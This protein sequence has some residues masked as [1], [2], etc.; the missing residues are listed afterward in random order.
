MATPT[1]RPHRVPV[2]NRPEPRLRREAQRLRPPTL[3]RLEQ[4][5]EPAAA[6]RLLSAA[7]PRA[8]RVTRGAA[9]V[10]HPD[11][12]ASLCACAAPYPPPSQLL[13]YQQQGCRQP[14]PPLPLPPPA[15]RW[16]REPSSSPPLSPVSSTPNK[17]LHTHTNASH[18]LSILAIA[19][20]Q[21]LYQSL[22]RYCL[23]LICH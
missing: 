13:L 18:I 2:R 3:V 22:L 16:R 6:L 11:I 20:Q 14:S 5:T 9:R 12:A 4:L 19:P 23:R 21:I 10:G 1:L 17:C 8:A 15:R 7:R